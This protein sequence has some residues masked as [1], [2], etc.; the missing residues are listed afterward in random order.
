[1]DH[2]RG[3]G[4]DRRSIGLDTGGGVFARPR[5]LR[6]GGDGNPLCP[7]S[8]LSGPTSAQRGR[9]GAYAK[10]NRKLGGV[11]APAWGHF[12]FG[13][14]NGLMTPPSGFTL[15]VRAFPSFS[16]WIV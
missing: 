6:I 15:M 5:P 2:G 10:V 14:S 4:A 1:M 3:A 12:F 16:T 9:S 8:D 11:R 13:N 7:G